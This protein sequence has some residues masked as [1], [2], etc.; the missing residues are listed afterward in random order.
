MY[1]FF[2]WHVSFKNHLKKYV[3]TMYWKDLNFQRLFK[4]FLH[5]KIVPKLYQYKAK[6]KP[7]NVSGFNDSQTQRK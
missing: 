5:M 2:F 4:C 3:K 7:T 6:S 1:S